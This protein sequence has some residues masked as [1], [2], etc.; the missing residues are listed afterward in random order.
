MMIL[1]DCFDDIWWDGVVD[2]FLHLIIIYLSALSNN[3]N[4]TTRFRLPDMNFSIHSTPHN[5]GIIKVNGR[6]RPCPAVA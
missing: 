2:G 6:D 3:S 1:I 4:N 5:K